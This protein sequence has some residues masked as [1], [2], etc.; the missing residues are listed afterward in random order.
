MPI[1]EYVCDKCGHHHKLSAW[2]RV[3]MLSDE[4]SF[5]EWDR[6]IYPGDPLSFGPEYAQ[7]LADDRAKTRIRAAMGKL[8]T[9][10]TP[11]RVDHD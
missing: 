3:G 10:L 7:K 2:E 4:G 8:R 11:K 6:D 9:M 1:Y 5:R